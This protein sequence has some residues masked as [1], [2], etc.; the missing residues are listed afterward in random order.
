MK[1]LFYLFLILFSLSNYS[2]TKSEETLGYA[3]GYSGSETKL[4]SKFDSLLFEKKYKSIKS[5][6][7]SKIPGENFLAVVLCRRLAN[8]KIITL[9]KLETERITQLFKSEQKVPLCGGCTYN[10]EIEISKLLANQENT[11]AAMEFF[12]RVQ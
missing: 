4:V 7:F 11:T 12:F 10:E 5:L 1:K 3:C 9:T 8:E 6:L 2:Q